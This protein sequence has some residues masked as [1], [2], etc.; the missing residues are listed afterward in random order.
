M[1]PCRH[2]LVVELGDREELHHVPEAR[3]IGDVLRRHP[4]DPFAIDV[5]RG[6]ARVERDRREDRALRSRVAALHVGG[7]VGLRVAEAL[8][9]GERLVEAPPVVGHLRED[10]V[11]RA[12]HDPGHARHTLADQ[13]LLQ[14]A[15]QGD[16]PGDGGL[17]RDV[18]ARGGGGVEHLIARAGQQFLVRARDRLALRERL[19]DERPGGLDPAEQL[20]HDVDL[21]VVDHGLGVVGEHVG[22]QRHVPVPRPIADRDTGHLDTDTGPALDVVGVLVEDPHD[23]RTDRPA[24]E[25]ADAHGAC[26][27]APPPPASSPP[28]PIQAAIRISSS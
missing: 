24:A 26:A 23:G 6:D 14:G 27:H 28:A 17:E 21:R 9:L 2:L 15:D 20:T 4:R 5:G 1:D 3:G 8:R 16:P 22:R 19:E 7:G 18:E 12:V 11:R 13:R 10:V 25:Q